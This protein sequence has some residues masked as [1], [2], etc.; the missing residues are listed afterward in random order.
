MVRILFVLNSILTLPF[1]VLALVMP[2]TVFSQFGIQLDPAGILIARGYAAAL[3]GYGIV[4]FL[5]RNA[6]E[7]RTVRGFLLSMAIFNG[8]EA[9][10][11]GVAGV[12]GVAGAAIFGNV[13]IHGIVFVLCIVSLVRQKAVSG[14][15]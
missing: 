15:T 5:M 11:Q 10:I 14:T 8:V 9:M 6:L 2:A 7:F 13:A 4:L 3:I 1:G 12:Q